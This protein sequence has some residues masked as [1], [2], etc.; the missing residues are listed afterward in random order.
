M[1]EV[2]KGGRVL[3]R[4][5]TFETAVKNACKERKL[6]GAPWSKFSIQRDALPDKAGEPFV[7][8]PN[9]SGKFEATHFSMAS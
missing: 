9:R 1:F 8:E 3:S 2:I 7:W 5:K 6:C 4:H